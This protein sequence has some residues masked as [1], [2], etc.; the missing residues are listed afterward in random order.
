MKTIRLVLLSILLAGCD[1]L[2]P[3]ADET[4]GK[5]NFVSAVSIIE[6]HQLRNHI[7]PDSLDELEYLGDWDAIW[8]SAVRNE[9]V[10]G[11]NNLY[12]ERG[13]IGEP[14]LKIPVGFKIAPGLRD[15]NVEWIAN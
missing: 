9:R 7:Y 4:F 10:E 13:W 11:G 5:Q 3:G 12:V 14:E 1:S 6:L 2:F 15:S 8:L